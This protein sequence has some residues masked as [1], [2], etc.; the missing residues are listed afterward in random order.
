MNVLCKLSHNEKIILNNGN[1][2]KQLSNLL[3]VTIHEASRRIEVLG[4]ASIHKAK[5]LS[6]RGLE[7]LFCSIVSINVYI[8]IYTFQAFA[9]SGLLYCRSMK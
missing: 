5:A 6:P 4:L 8:E 7:I 1:Y 2:F 3:H 9:N